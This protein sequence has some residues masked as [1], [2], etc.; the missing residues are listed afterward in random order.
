ML[1]IG[2]ST[3]LPH[4]QMSTKL[5][6]TTK[7]LIRLIPVSLV[8]FLSSCLFKVPGQYGFYQNQQGE[9]HNHSQQ[10][11]QHRFV[12]AEKWAKRFENPERDKWQKPDS[13]IAALS[14]KGN[15]IVVDIGSATGYFPIRFAKM[16]TDGKVYGID[17]EETMVDYLNDRAKQEGILNLK[18]ILG[19]PD[20]PLIP[21]DADIIFICDTYHHIENRVEYFSRL[22]N[23]FKPDGRLVIVDFVKGDIPVG[24]PDNMKLSEQVVISELSE[25]GYKLSQEVELLPYQYFLIFRTNEQ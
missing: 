20:N 21:E 24:P 7:L 14:L 3:M 25:A 18:S 4:T 9:T 12:D 13:V 11:G 6:A 2:V 19:K 23:D 10:K 15:E 22:K 5:N 17:I 8:I 16:V 1:L